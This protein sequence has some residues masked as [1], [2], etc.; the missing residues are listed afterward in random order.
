MSLTGRTTWNI[1]QIYLIHFYI[2]LYPPGK[3][4]LEADWSNLFTSKVDPSDFF[5]AS[6]AGLP[7]SCD[8]QQCLT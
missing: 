2:D 6:L 3:E 5:I 1:F 4:H 7:G 8:V